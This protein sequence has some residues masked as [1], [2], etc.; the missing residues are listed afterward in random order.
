M[1]NPNLEPGQSG[2]DV[3]ALVYL[4]VCMGLGLALLQVPTSTAQVVNQMVPVCR[5]VFQKSNM[6]SV[7]RNLCVGTQK[8]TVGIAYK[9]TSCKR[10]LWN[11]HGCQSIAESD[12]SNNR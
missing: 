4:S 8:M 5:A 2:F 10:S 12:L 6:T 9:H 1:P 7:Y 11:L 3:R